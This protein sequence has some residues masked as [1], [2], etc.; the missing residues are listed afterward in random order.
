MS[1]GSE[2]PDLDLAELLAAAD[3]ETVDIPSAEEVIALARKAEALSRHATGSLRPA[4]SGTSM[5]PRLRLLDK[6]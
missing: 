5:N 6:K 2:E 1:T 3:G 4:D